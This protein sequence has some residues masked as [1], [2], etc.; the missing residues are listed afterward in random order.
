MK[1]ILE[2]QRFF[3]NR[4]GILQN[5][6]RYAL[7]C[8]FD[9]RTILVT[10]QSFRE[11]FPSHSSPHPTPMI[12]FRSFQLPPSQSLTP[13]TVSSPNI[14]SQP[15]IPPPISAPI[16]IHHILPV[17]QSVYSSSCP[18]RVDFINSGMT[19]RSHLSVVCKWVP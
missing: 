1:P 17:N 3:R 10:P 16:T 11:S 12:F 7:G 19:T 14:L 6:F 5:V 9:A 4:I 8:F 18:P 13:L 15:Y 2:S